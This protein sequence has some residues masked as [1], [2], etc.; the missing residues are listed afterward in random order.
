LRANVAD[1]VRGRGGMAVDVAIK[2]S[3]ASHAV[4]MGRL[5]IEGGVKLLLRKLRDQQAQPFHVLGVEDALKDLL[6]VF[7]GDQL[8][9]RNI[10][11][12]GPGD[13]EY[14]GG[15]FRQEV[16]GQV[17][18]QVEALQAFQFLDFMLREDHPA[19]LVMRVRQRQKTYGKQ[20]FLADFFRRLLPQLFPGHSL[21]QP[22]RRSDRYRL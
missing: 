12:V 9:L 6:K 3:Y 21:R 5:A 10:A 17:E 14:G 19:N 13:Q 8:A 22:R 4:R 16:L 1:D 20:L 11:Q 15:E 18:V 7:D 2:A